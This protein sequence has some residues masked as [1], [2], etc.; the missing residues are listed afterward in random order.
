MTRFLSA[1]AGFTNSAPFAG[2]LEIRA[3]R[4]QNGLVALLVEYT[5]NQGDGWAYA[6]EA[7]GRFYERVMASAGQTP[8]PQELVGGVMPERMFQLGQ[9]TAELHVALA[10]R[11]EL[12]DFAPEDFS[13]LWQRSL[14]QAMRGA[15]GRLLRQFR[16]QMSGLPEAVRVRADRILH[17][18]AAILKAYAPLLDHK[19]SAVK[20]RVHG[21]YHLG[22]VLNTGK[23][24]VI[25]DFGGEPRKTLGERSLKRSPLVD[26]AGMLRSFDYAASVTLRQQHEPDQAALAPWAELWVKTISEAFLEGYFAVARPAKLVPADEADT[27]LLV[28]VFLLDKAIY[29]VGYELSYRPDFVE[30]PLRAVETLLADAAATAD[31]VPA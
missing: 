9:R 30:I 10:S 27:A 2:A 25:I 3:P 20:T 6:L 19:I 11:P 16:R 18:R 12:T 1:D 17:D 14:Y 5:R 26:V 7:A 29:E 31:S 8:D 24:F 22:Q 28:R 13:T 15:A 21:D 4:D 23:D